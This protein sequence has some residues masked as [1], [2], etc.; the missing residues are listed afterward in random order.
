MAARN[1]SYVYGRVRRGVNPR[2]L[3]ADHRP[4]GTDRV[5]L[6]GSCEWLVLRARLRQLIA[7]HPFL[8]LGAAGAVA[9]LLTGARRVDRITEL[10]IVLVFAA[11][12]S[13]TWALQRRKPMC[14][15]VFLHL[16]RTKLAEAHGLKPAELEPYLD[17]A[18]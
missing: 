16:R 2:T 15:A 8:V 10:I 17:A 14:K 5:L 18:A 13:L 7:Q 3:E 9:G 12:V 4:L 11:W 1:W 6:C